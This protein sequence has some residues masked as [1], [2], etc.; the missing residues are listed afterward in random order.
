M[1]TACRSADSGT[2]RHAPL[3]PNSLPY[4]THPN[5]GHVWG[6]VNLRGV[7]LP[8][9]DLRELM[10][11]A[12]TNPSS[13]NVIIVMQIGSQMQGIVVDAVNDI[14]EIDRD[15]LQSPPDVGRTNDGAIEGIA[16]FDDRMVMV[17]APNRLTG[18]GVQ[19]LAA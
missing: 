5:R 17:L 3:L 1:Q 16:T 18:P 7:V 6:V 13:R 2:D 12:R 4:A 14:V 9:F 11:W 15:E 10:G 19:S 8:V